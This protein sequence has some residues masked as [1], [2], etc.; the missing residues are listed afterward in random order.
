MNILIIYSHPS[1]KSYTFQVL[2]RL[3]SVILKQNWNLEISDLYEMNFQSD[4]SAEEYEREGFAKLD[5]P[6][7]EDVLAEHKK[8]EKA[9]CIIFLYP[10]WWSDCPAKLKGW[11]DRV[12]SVGYA[13]GQTESFPKMKII[14]HG[15]TICTAGHPNDFL[16]EIGIAQS[17]EKI[18]LEDR[19]GKRFEN[20]EMLILGGTLE[21]EK[22]MEGHFWEIEEIVTK[23]KQ[24]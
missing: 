15:I 3:K 24:F 21:L 22:V 12:Y 10:V 16:N 6:I 23:L 14:P 20:K 2:E 7:S 13:Y 5:L 1:K 19:L 8:I 17:M 9:D 4:M 18:M 11:F